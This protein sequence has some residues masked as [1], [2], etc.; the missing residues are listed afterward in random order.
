[1]FSEVDKLLTEIR[2]CYMELDKFWTEEI[3]RAIESLKMRRIN[4][5][6][7]ERWKTYRAGIKQTIDSWKVR[8]C[9]LLLCC[10][11]P[12]DQNTLLRVCYQGAMFKPCAAKM[13]SRLRFALSL[14]RFGSPINP[15][16]RRSLTLGK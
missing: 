9:F 5:T 3:S 16:V 11:F 15:T 14:F 13:H 12:T 2:Q 8:Y 1:M 7:F 10:A 6:D 4:P